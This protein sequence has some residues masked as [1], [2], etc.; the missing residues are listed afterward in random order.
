MRTIKLEDGGHVY[1][2]DE[3]GQR[4]DALITTCWGNRELDL[5]DPQV[6]LPAINIVFVLKASDRRDQYGQ[7]KDHRTS[8]V[9]KRNQSAPGN[10]WFHPAELNT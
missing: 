2:V 3:H 5:D 1:Y 9:H 8:C 7:Q 4:H 6:F 10:F